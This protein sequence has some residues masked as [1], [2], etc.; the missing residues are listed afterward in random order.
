MNPCSEEIKCPYCE[1]ILETKPTRKKKCRWCGQQIVVRSGCL[2]TEDAAV[3]IDWLVRL[4]QFDVSASD[5]EYHRS[6]LSQQLRMAVN[7]RDTIWRILNSLIVNNRNLGKRWRVFHE[8]ATFVVQEGKDPK[9]YLVEAHKIKLAAYAE[10]GVEVLRV[11]SYSHQQDD[12]CCEACA[13]LFGKQLSTQEAISQMPI[14]TVCEEGWCTC[15]YISEEEWR[16]EHSPSRVSKRQLQILEW[17]NEL[18][19]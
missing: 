1:G 7:S 9:P 16:R 14:P 11:V 4:A 5:F 19:F 18:G 15:D 10:M 3:E 6:E 17:L 8:M 13:A 2:V 12:S